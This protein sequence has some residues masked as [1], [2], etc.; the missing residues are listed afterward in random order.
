MSTTTSHPASAS[1]DA[2]ELRQGQSIRSVYVYEAPVRIWHW[3]NALSITVLCV[4]GYFIGQ[5]LLTMPGEASAHYLMGYIMAVGMF[6]R[7]YWALVGNHHAKKLFWVPMF[8]KT[9]WR[10]VFNMLRWYLF[11]IPKPNQYV[12]HNPLARLAMFGF[13]LMFSNFMLLT[14]FA[15]YGEGAQMGSWQERLFGWVIPLFGQSQDVHTWHRLGMWGIVTFVLLHI[16]AAIREDIMGRQSIV[17]TMISGHR[18]F[19]E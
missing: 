16:Y 14:G 12:G 17:S 7:A 15:L 6:A 19:K 13:Y 11:L 5:P 18:T 1:H 2:R 3:L 9:Y 8:Q 10:E 4:T